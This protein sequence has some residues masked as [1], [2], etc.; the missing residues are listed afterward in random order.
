MNA[1]VGFLLGLIV[2]AVANKVP[3]GTEIAAIGHWL[4]SFIGGRL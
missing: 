1:A 2:A 4:L 3:I